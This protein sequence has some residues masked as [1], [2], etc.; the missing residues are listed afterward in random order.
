M[1]INNQLDDA[2]THGAT[3]DFWCD[4]P[5]GR[6]CAVRWPSV[7][8]AAL[9]GYLSA[10]CGLD[11]GQPGQ[12]G[13][14][15]PKPSQTRRWLPMQDIDAAAE[16]AGPLSHVGCRSRKSTPL[17]A[18]RGQQLTPSS[19]HGLSPHTPSGG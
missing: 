16:A 17:L 19:H 1:T 4:V 18:R 8:A 7:G 14:R 2:D 5:S 9:V 3:S 6:A 10:G 13:R 12:P 11:R 15:G